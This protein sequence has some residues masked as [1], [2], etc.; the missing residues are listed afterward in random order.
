LNIYNLHHNAAPVAEMAVALMLAA[1]RRIPSLDRELRKHNWEP[2]YQN[3]DQSFLL[4]GRRVLVLGYGHVGRHV[5]QLCRA[6]GMQVVGIK[7]TPIKDEGEIEVHSIESLPS[8]LQTTQV[9]VICVPLTIQT[10]GLID[11]EMLARLP[12]EAILVNVARGEVIDE[13]ALYQVLVDGTIAAA[14]LDVWFNYP[15]EADER[16]ATPP[17]AYPFEQLEN[18]VLTP[19][20]AGKVATT[21]QMRMEH[22]AT[23]LNQLAEGRQ[24]AGVVDI[25]R[26]Y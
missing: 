16:S 9:L 4:A 12:P 11:A 20:V 13:K 22:L 23:L 8:Q 14:G 24:P 10:R 26:G 1:A 19:H 3:H 15:T 18:V 2:R 5:G 25:A 17:S 7:R 21:E 6:L